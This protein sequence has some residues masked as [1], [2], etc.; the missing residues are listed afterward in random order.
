MKRTKIE[1]TT[2]LVNK[3]WYSFKHRVPYARRYQ[4]IISRRGGNVV[5]D[6]IGFRTL[7]TNTGEQPG[8]IAGISHIFRTL[9]IKRLKDIAFSIK[10]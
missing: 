10:S 5:I 4:E 7:N 1:V 3:L 9:V 8:G 6:H 2:D